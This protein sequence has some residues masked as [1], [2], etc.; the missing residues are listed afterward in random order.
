MNLKEFY[1]SINVNPEEVFHRFANNEAMLA[2]FLKKFLEDQT[3]LELTQAVENKDWEA[4]FRAAHTLKGLSG[5][6]GFQ[7]LF[8]LSSKIVERYRAGDYEVIPDWFEK[9]AICYHITVDNLVMYL[10]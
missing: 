8:D 2:K 3:Y 5:N 10:E 4:T 1:N 9:L 6:F 7:E